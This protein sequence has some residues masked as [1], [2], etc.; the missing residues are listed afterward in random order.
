[1]AN[2]ICNDLLRELAASAEQGQSTPDVCSSPISP[3]QLAE[4]VKVVEAGTITKQIAKDVFIEMFQTGD[5]PQTIIDRKGLS[6]QQ[7]D[8]LIEGLCREA[9]ANN[10]KAVAQFKAGNAKALNALKGPVMKA[11]RGQANPAMLDALLRQLIE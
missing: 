2:Y 1:M 8:A 6:Q 4:L 9:I 7:D 5:D 3:R 11:T 10:A